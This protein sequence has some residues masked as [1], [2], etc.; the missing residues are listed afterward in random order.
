MAVTLA[1][2]MIMTSP[3]YAV[4]VNTGDAN[5][6]AKDIADIL[7]YIFPLMG[8]FFALSGVIKWVMA[9][10]SEQPEQ[11]A[12]AVKEIIIGVVCIVFRA[13]LWDPISSVIF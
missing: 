2:A 12:S 10:R 4:S 6:K 7:T 11:Q 8:A 3:V 1:S 5:N 13:F 9:F